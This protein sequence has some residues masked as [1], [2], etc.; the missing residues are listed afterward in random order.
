MYS[1]L[2]WMSAI[3]SPGERT[4]QYGIFSLS[5]ARNQFQAK[6]A[7]GETVV[8]GTMRTGSRVAE[9]RHVADARVD[10]VAVEGDA[11][12]LELRAGGVDVLDLQG[13]RPVVGREG[14]AE[15]VHL[16]DRQRQRARLE[17]AGGHAAP[18]LGAGE[19]EGV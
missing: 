1:P 2:S 5:S 10:G 17:L 12:R 4:E 11:G 15:G 16:H 7:S 13:D 8:P 3:V 19:P 14:L 6:S 18:L 9:D